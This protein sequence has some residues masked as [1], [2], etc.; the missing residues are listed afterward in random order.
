MD[1][2]PPVAP[3]TCPACGGHHPFDAVPSF[4]GYDFT[5]W[6]FQ[7]CLC[8]HVV[9]DIEGKQ[10]A[11]GSDGQTVAEIA[12]ALQYVATRG[13][14]YGGESKAADLRDGP[15]TIRHPDPD[16]RPNEIKGAI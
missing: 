1:T 7:C 14:A 11:P 5:G 10:A 2:K 13:R 16:V 15:P 8:R 4:A 6:Q 9:F 12:D 3:T